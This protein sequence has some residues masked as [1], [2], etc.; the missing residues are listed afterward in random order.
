MSSC[1]LQ[2][3][4]D[5]RNH[6]SQ[7]TNTETE[8]QTPHVL[9]HKW[10]LNSENTWTQGREH[11]TPGSVGGNRSGTV[12]GGELGRHIGDVE[13]G[14]K[15]HCHVCTYA[16]MLHVLHMYPKTLN[17]IKYILKI[18]IIIIKCCCKEGGNTLMQQIGIP[19]ADLYING[20]LICDKIGIT[21]QF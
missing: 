20:H 3:H 1:P 14:S 15:P 7:Q 6:H 13:E 10:E 5:A 2:Q 21:E 19:Y 4:D 9:T 11:H 17:A 18:I 8:N 12:V 16:T